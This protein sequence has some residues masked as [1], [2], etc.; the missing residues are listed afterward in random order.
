MQNVNAP[1]GVPMRLSFT[2]PLTRA[3]PLVTLNTPSLA[4]LQALVVRE[5][6]GVVGRVAAAEVDW[7]DRIAKGLVVRYDK[8]GGGGGAC[9]IRTDEELLACWGEMEFAEVFVG[10]GRAAPG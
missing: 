5:Y 4:A 10:D 6:E 3:N 1:A 8:R 2:W 9:V 7:D